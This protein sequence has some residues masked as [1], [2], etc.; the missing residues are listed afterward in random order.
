MHEVTRRM[1]WGDTPPHLADPELLLTREWLLTNGLG[2]FAMGTAAGVPTRRYHALLVAALS[3]PVER[4]VAL[5]AVV[6][7]IALRSESGPGGRGRAPVSW[8]WTLLLSRLTA[9]ISAST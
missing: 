5:N 6:D 4:V 8:A 9:L 3:P 2:G 1:S 7:Q